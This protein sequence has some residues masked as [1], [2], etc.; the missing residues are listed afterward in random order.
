[1]NLMSYSSE[2]YL[3]KRQL[4]SCLQLVIAQTTN[5]DEFLQIY[6]VSSSRNSGCLLLETL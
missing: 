4:T 6:L 3:I 5:T 1:M 2:V